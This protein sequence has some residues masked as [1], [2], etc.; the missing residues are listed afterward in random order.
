MGYAI[1]AVVLILAIAGFVVF[2]VLN[3]TGKSG[4]AAEGDGDS[5]GMGPDHTPLGDT[6]EHAGEQGADGATVGDPEHGGRGADAAAHR[7][8][9]GEAEGGE[10]LDFEG[11]QPARHAAR[12]DE[13]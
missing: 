1:A 4:P 3:A 11:A 6:S 5:P 12:R 10:R 13:G 9:P 7:S 8:R 2:F